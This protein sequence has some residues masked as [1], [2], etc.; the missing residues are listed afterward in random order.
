MVSGVTTS[1]NGVN[2]AY[3]EGP[4]WEAEICARREEEAAQFKSGGESAFMRSCR[5]AA[6]AHALLDGN[7]KEKR[8]GRAC[9]CECVERLHVL[10][11]GMGLW[12]PVCRAF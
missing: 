11:F 10:S 6:G 1:G 5:K 2:I 4:G 7:K 9:V 8:V 12:V 3:G